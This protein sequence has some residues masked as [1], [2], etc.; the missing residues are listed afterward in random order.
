M[1]DEAAIR[2]RFDTLGPYL[3][4]RQRRVFATSEA[5]AAGRGGI[6]A[7]SRITGIARSTIGRGLDEVAAGG[8]PDGRVRRAGAGRKTLEKTDRRLIED[9]ERIVAPTQRGDPEQPL[10]WTIKSLRQIARSLRDLGHCISH[11]SVGA[12]LRAC[13]YSLQAN[14]KTR[15]GSRH[16]DRNAQFEAINQ[17]VNAALAEGQPAKRRNWLA[18][19]RIRAG[20]GARRASPK[21]CGPTTS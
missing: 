20:H 17:T 21:R 4:E 10:R 14:R 5:L 18:I 16:P 12:I 9:L 7:V 8:A 2:R 1:I 19:S 3:D 13:G 6:A 11:T 15:E